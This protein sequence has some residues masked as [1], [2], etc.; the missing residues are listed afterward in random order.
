MFES[1]A[2]SRILGFCAVSGST[3]V[4]ISEGRL[5]FAEWE[6]LGSNILLPSHKSVKQPQPGNTN[7]GGRLSTVDLHVKVA[8]FIKIYIIL[9]I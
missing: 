9:L 2:R 1:K 4:V 7:R 5:Q 8:C 6:S 3:Q